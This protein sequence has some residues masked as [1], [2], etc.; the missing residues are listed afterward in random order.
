MLPHCCCLGWCALQLGELELLVPPP[1]SS[2]AVVGFVLKFLAGYGNTLQ[3]SPA[4][5]TASSSSSSTAAST[6]AE[7]Q[8]IRTGST[9]DVGEAEEA[10]LASFGTEPRRDKALGVRRMVSVCA[11]LSVCLCF[12]CCRVSAAQQQAGCS[13]APVAPC[14]DTLHDGQWRGC[15]SK[16]FAHTLL[17]DECMCIAP[18]SPHNR[19]R[20]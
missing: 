2:A 14:S 16:F 19:L 6:L 4:F 10:V 3:S 7:E 8:G 15:I 9:A 13:H 17:M 11:C 20:R 12:G 18:P 1:P 5:S